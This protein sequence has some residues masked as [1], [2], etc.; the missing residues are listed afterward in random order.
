ML[1]Q[2]TGVAVQP[3][4]AETWFTPYVS[5]STNVD[6]VLGQ[7]MG[8]GLPITRDL[9][10]EYGGTVRFVAPTANFATAIEVVIPE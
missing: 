6:P 7:G 5:T 9:V 8:L 3:A 4:E 1:V 10:S 2:N